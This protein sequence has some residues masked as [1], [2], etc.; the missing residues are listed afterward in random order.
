MERKSKITELFLAIRVLYWI[1]ELI[2]I[3]NQCERS[4]SYFYRYGY[5]K[6]LTLLTRLFV[7]I[8]TFFGQ[9]VCN[10]RTNYNVIISAT[11]NWQQYISIACVATSTASISADDIRNAVAEGNMVAYGNLDVIGL[12]TTNSCQGTNVHAL[13]G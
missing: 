9:V 12:W 3:D 7:V 1:F 8:T 6:L 11:E 4:A 2:N 13:H 10:F 5:Q